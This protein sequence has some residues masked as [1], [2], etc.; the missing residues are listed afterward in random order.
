MA[1]DE[2]MAGCVLPVEIWELRFGDWLCL[3]V[4]KW[5][6]GWMDERE[7]G[8]GWMDGWMRGRK[9]RREMGAG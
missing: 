3:F 7:K 1:G 2:D 9:E 4:R 6:D 8:E 5:M